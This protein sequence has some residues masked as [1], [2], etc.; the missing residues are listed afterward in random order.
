MDWWWPGVGLVPVF[1]LVHVE[2]VVFMV[3]DE[4]VANVNEF[5]LRLAQTLT[6]VV[7]SLGTEGDG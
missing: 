1:G 4:F 3:V 5:R 7:F 2:D 6:D